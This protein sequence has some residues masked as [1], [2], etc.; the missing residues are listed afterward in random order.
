MNGIGIELTNTKTEMAKKGKKGKKTSGANVSVESLPSTDLPLSDM[1]EE[2][3]EMKEALSN[4][5]LTNAN[6]ETPVE[7]TIDSVRNALP[8]DDKKLISET[9]GQTKELIATTG[10]DIQSAVIVPD[11]NMAKDKIT[12]QLSTEK[13]SSHASTMMTSTKTTVAKTMTSSAT[14]ATTQL[15]DG[16]ISKQSQNI[17]KSLSEKADQ[18]TKMVA[19]D[20]APVSLSKSIDSAQKTVIDQSKE[21]LNTVTKTTNAIPQTFPSLNA[22]KVLSDGEDDDDQ[23]L[24]VTLNEIKRRSNESLSNQAKK[25]VVGEVVTKKAIVHESFTKVESTKTETKSGKLAAM[26]AAVSTAAASAASVLTG[27]SASTTKEITEI[28]NA[29]V[30][31]N[32]K[33]GQS[34]PSNRIYNKVETTTSS[35]TRVLE[36]KG[37]G[38][39]AATDKK[40]LP[41]PPMP[42]AP[43]PDIPKKTLSKTTTETTKE[44][45]SEVKYFMPGSGSTPSA[46]YIAKPI[47]L[48]NPPPPAKDRAVYSNTGIPPTTREVQ[49][50]KV[51]Q[52]TKGKAPM[53]PKE[54]IVETET[55]KVVKTE[56]K[57]PTTDLEDDLSFSS[58]VYSQLL[59]RL[60]SAGLSD[61]SGTSNPPP[62]PPNKS[63]VNLP[64]VATT[65]KAAAHPTATTTTTTKTTQISN[66]ATS[67]RMNQDHRASTA[68]T[69]IPP[70]NTTTVPKSA[71]RVLSH[72]KHSSLSSFTNGSSIDYSSDRVNVMLAQKYR[73]EDP[74]REVQRE[75]RAWWSHEKNLPP[76]RE[77]KTN[78]FLFLFYYGMRSCDL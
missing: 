76:K 15:V 34:V 73:G 71:N 30:T 78:T 28:K 66:L 26:G 54:T 21:T 44:T 68:P 42:D 7:T 1:K 45:T 40:T 32:E 52:S 75:R 51:A 60:S 27:K 14:S 33:T 63:W 38:Y 12:K 3:T 22:Q 61:G 5:T 47:P 23:P 37:T 48:S 46:S 41:P 36:K 19:I 9:L 11:L 17:Q 65:S 53:M 59:E 62:A 55:V 31:T 74:N 18:V 69:R 4:V 67:G 20:A 16:I 72:S 58:E 25:A 49:M 10:K 29:A 24:G 2:A 6:I 43:L 35:V 77:E 39:Q 57:K 13:I 64:P 50:A 70:K 56:S 8:H